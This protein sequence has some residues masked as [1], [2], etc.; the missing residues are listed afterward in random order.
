VFEPFYRPGGRAEA[1]GGW[2]LGLALV[3]Q[4][5]GLHGGSV[6]VE[7]G[8]SGGARFVVEFADG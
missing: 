1:A 8:E 7:A 5:A 2:G 3:K 4:I 6:R